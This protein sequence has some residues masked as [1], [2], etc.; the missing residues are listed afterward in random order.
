MGGKGCGDRNK[1]F[2]FPRI[3]LCFKFTVVIDSR[4][5][6]FSNLKS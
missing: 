5:A 4:N 6:P 1:D 3:Q 2:S